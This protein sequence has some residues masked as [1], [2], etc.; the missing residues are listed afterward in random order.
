[1]CKRCAPLCVVLLA[2]FVFIC[3]GCG[4][5]GSEDDAFKRLSKEYFK[6]YFR[7]NPI[8]ATWAG[9]HRYDHELD[10]VSRGAVEAQTASLKTFLARLEKL[11]ESALSPDN[12]IDA[13]I[14]AD[15]IKL[16]I[17]NSE[18]L[19]PLETDPMYYT[20]L[21]GNSINY[22]IERDYAPIG[23]RLDAVADRLTQFPRVIDQALANLSNPPKSCTETAISQNRGLMALIREDVMTAAQAAP[24][25]SEKV[26]NAARGALD[27]LAAFQNFLEKDLINRSLGD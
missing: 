8:L 24:E 15:G 12:R 20:S 4:R 5:G 3:A 26:D 11:D 13:E 16:D 21:L 19:R 18:G 14:L 17:L 7:S 1:M 2:S 27:A 23:E 10:D 9:E 6:E 25:K 22:L